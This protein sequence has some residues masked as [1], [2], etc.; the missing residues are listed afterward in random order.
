MEGSI[1]LLCLRTSFSCNHLSGCSPGAYRSSVYSLFET[2]RPASF[3]S[4]PTETRRSSSV[5]LFLPPTRGSIRTP[6]L[7]AEEAEAAERVRDVP[8]PKIDKSGRFCSP[9]AARELALLILY[10]ACLEGSDPIR[11]FEKRVNARREPGYEFDKASLLEYNH[12]SFGGPPV[13]TET[14]EEADELVRNDEK[15]STIEAEVLLAP[16]KLVYSK[17]VLRLA[18]KLLAAVV[19]KWD[20]HIVVIDKVA[21]SNWKNAPAG[22]ILELSVLHLAMSEIAVVGTRHPIVI[23]E[24]VDLAKRFCDGSAPRIINGCLRTFVKDFTGGGGVASTPPQASESKQ[25]VSV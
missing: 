25:E 8:M 6:E 7:T 14:N 13:K 15:E 16:P 10:A 18:R 3:I 22:R 4:F 20:S 5:R 23:N 9:R 21:P 11:L 17:L 1:S 19:D 12:M 24:A 2:L